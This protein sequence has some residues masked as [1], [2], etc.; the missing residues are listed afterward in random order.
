MR[1]MKR[2]ATLAAASLVWLGP[3]DWPPLRHRPQSSHSARRRNC[4]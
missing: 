1:I 3:R 4:R 2:A